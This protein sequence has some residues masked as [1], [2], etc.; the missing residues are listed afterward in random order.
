M[1][2]KL[3]LKGRVQAVACR[4]YCSRYGRRLKIQGSATNLSDGSVQVLLNTED[5][6]QAE[7]YINAIKNNTNKLHFWGDIRSI[8]VSHYEGPIHGDDQF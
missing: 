4:H 3:I 1:A 6:T 5:K 7:I 2:F 8:D